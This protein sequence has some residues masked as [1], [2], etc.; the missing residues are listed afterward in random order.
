MCSFMYQRVHK[1]NLAI[2]ETSRYLIL[3]TGVGKGLRDGGSGWADGWVGWGKS[4]SQASKNRT[5]VILRREEQAGGEEKTSCE[6]TA[7]LFG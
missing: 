5:G 1:N 2:T 3:Q 4:A 6:N 7:A